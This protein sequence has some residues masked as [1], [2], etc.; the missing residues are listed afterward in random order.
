VAPAFPA[1]KG[2]GKAGVRI[3]RLS[4]LAA[5]DSIWAAKPDS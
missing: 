5:R 3:L 2:I 1:V 4:A